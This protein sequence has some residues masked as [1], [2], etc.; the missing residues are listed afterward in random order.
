MLIAPV[1][2]V[3]TQRFTG[4]LL[5]M[6]VKVVLVG[7]EAPAELPTGV[8]FKHYPT[9]WKILGRVPFFWRFAK[10]ISR[11]RLWMLWKRIS[12]DITH[13]KWIGREA[14]ACHEVGIKPLVLTCWGSDIN[15][16]FDD[17]F[18]GKFEPSRREKLGKALAS[19]KRVVADSSQTLDRCDQ[20][21]GS[22]VERELM[23][24]GIDTTVFIPG[25]ESEAEAWRKA[26]NI[27]PNVKIILSIRGMNWKYGQDDVVRAFASALTTCPD[28]YLI[29][30]R[31][32]VNSQEYLINVEDLIK[33]L[34]LTGHIRWLDAVEQKQMPVLYSMA[35]VVV[36]YPVVDAFPVS[37]LEAAACGKRIVSRSLPAYKGVGVENFIEFVRSGGSEELG[38]SIVNVLNEPPETRV[39]LSEKARHWALEN[40][41][42]RKCVEKLLG[43]YQ[44]IISKEKIPD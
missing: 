18:E 20:L 11:L 39:M 31:Y 16:F 44:S 19:A 15:Q 29:L 32:C 2:S 34:N 27:P 7:R 9:D 1:N 14:I 37:F 28:T 12:P 24:L 30:L 10:K 26:L 22:K 42:E 35:D 43:V 5:R 36:N 6:G 17:D 41:D 4:W 38:A 8:R 40:G 33:E 23:Y 21:A 13:L 25:Y 3:H